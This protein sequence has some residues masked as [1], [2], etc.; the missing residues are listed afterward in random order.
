[1]IDEKNNNNDKEDFA[2]ELDFSE[3]FGGIP[4]NVNLTHNI[5]CVP[6]QKKKKGAVKPL[7]ADDHSEKK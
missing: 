4:D 5:G 1:M 6:D 7:K 2:D 3:G